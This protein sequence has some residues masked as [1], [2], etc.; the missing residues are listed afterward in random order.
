[1]TPGA[2]ETIYAAFRDTVKREFREKERRFCAPERRAVLENH[3]S[4]ERHEQFSKAVS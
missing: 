3:N 1:M 2:T 4:V